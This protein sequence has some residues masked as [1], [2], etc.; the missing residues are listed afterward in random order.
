M[1]R[2]VSLFILS[3][4]LI[5]AGALACIQTPDAAPT[6]NPPGSTAA[7]T[8]KPGNLTEAPPAASLEGVDWFLE[9]FGEAGS[10]KSVLPGAEITLR[11]DGS[12]GRF[13]G[14]GGVNRYFGGYQATD[15]KLTLTGPIGSTMMAGPQDAMDQESRYFTLLQTAESFKIEGKQLQITCGKTTLNFRQK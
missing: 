9:S 2:Q 3:M 1:R 4:L 7:L 12:N 13:G 11:F 14:S 6:Q 15:G 5:G 8:P 10:L